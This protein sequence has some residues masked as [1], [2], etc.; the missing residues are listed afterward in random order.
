MLFRSVWLPVALFPAMSTGLPLVLECPV[1]DSTRR[2][3][4]TIQA[5]LSTWYPELH[6]V[7]VTAP[8]RRSFARQKSRVAQL[9]TGGV[10]SFYTLNV[11]PEI[12]TFLYVHDLVHDTPEVRARIHDLL[13]SVA[14]KKDATILEFAS[15]IRT[16]L[17]RYGEWGTQTHGAALASIAALVSGEIGTTFLPASHTYL[18][19]YPWGSHPVLDHLW[20]GDR[21]QL[22]HDG[23]D[24]TR[25][26]KIETVSRDSV[27]LSSLRVCWMTNSEINCSRCE[28]CLRTMTSLEIL[29]LLDRATTFNGPLDLDQ[30]RAVNLRNENDLSFAVENLEAARHAGRADIVEILDRLIQEFNQRDPIGTVVQS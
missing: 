2:A 6:V 28:K 14:A 22:I 9:F 10:D 1:S 24:A 7:D 30:L 13:G 12:D 8:R 21:H 26:Q 18:D 23:A 19:L 11:H 16:M 25:F 4:G 3:V 29:G 27:A 17:D 5:I 20:S 15:D